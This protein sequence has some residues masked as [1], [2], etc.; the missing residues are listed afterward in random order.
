[1]CRQVQRC[2]CDRRQQTE[3]THNSVYGKAFGL[4][5]SL[6]EPG[7]MKK[8]DNKNKEVSY[9]ISIKQRKINI[10]RDEFL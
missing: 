8:N 2:G 9:K 1:M 10:I 5:E 7:A 3:N 6:Q 4:D